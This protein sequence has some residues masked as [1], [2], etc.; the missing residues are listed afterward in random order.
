MFL[1][2]SLIKFTIAKTM[3][4]RLQIISIQPTIKGIAG[5]T[6]KAGCLNLAAT[7]IY[8]RDCGFSQ[9]K[10]ISHEKL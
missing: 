3:F 6:K 10:R 8:V 1:K 9:I 7:T 5:K 4:L 2:R